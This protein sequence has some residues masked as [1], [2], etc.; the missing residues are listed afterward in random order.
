MKRIKTFGGMLC[1][2]VFV[3][4]G[5]LATSCN[6]TEKENPGKENTGEPTPEVKEPVTFTVNAEASY[7]SATITG[8]VSEIVAGAEYGVVYGTAENPEVGETTF[9]K[10]IEEIAEDKTFTL[11]LTDLAEGTTYHYRA[12]ICEKGVYTYSDDATFVTKAFPVAEIASTEILNDQIK[13]TFKPGLPVSFDEE[14]KGSAIIEGYEIGV[15]YSTSEDFSGAKTRVL[16]RNDYGEEAYIVWNIELLLFS[17][18]YCRPYVKDLQSTYVKYYAAGAPCVSPVKMDINYV[19]IYIPEG[20]DPLFGT[21]TPAE[22]YKGFEASFSGGS[23]GFSPVKKDYSYGTLV[24][25]K[26]EFDITTE[27]VTEYKMTQAYKKGDTSPL[28][29][30]C[31]YTATLTDLTSGTYYRGYVKYNEEVI[32]YTEIK[33]LAL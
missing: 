19:D 16:T 21:P 22:T 29:P 7:T 8:T 26:N 33:Q 2:A 28:A 10:T 5:L 11:D 3:M 9:S 13:V 6:K 4:G 31:Y 27:G 14:D 23:D 25:T 20:Y 1:A 18:T 15:E 17:T 32:A 30:V 12:Y 24:S